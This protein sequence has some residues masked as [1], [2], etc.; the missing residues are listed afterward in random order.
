M[1]ET[2]TYLL[3]FITF[4]LCFAFMTLFDNKVTGQM[5]TSSS[6]GF[7]PCIECALPVCSSGQ[8]LSVSADSCTEC[9][10]CI[11]DCKCPDGER[12]DGE[13]CVSNS[14]GVACIALYAPVCGCDSKTYGNSCVAAGEGVKHFTQ[15]ECDSSSSGEISIPC[16]EDKDCPPGECP[17]GTTYTN[18]SCQD[19]KCFQ[20]QFFADPCLFHQ[21]SSSSGSI[22]GIDLNKK[23]VGIWKA[24]LPECNPE[25]IIGREI[26]FEDRNCIKCE[27][28]QILCIRGTVRVPDSCKEC[29]HCEKCSDLGFISLKLCV[30]NAILS[31]TSSPFGILES[32]SMI[33]SQKI[34]SANEIEVTFQDENEN[35][36]TVT[37]KLKNPRRLIIRFLTEHTARAKKIS[38]NIECFETSSSSS[39]SSSGG[40]E[41]C[42]SRGSCR[43]LNEEELPCPAGTECSGLPAYGCYPPGCPVPICL[44][45]DTK[46]RTNEIKKRVSDIQIGDIVLSDGEKPAKVIK[47]TKVEVQNH[48][49]LRILL[50][51]ATVLEAS[52]GHPTADGRTL[53]DLKKG[54]QLDG[55]VIVKTELI[56]YNYKYTYD[57]LP[58]SETGNYYANGVLVGSTL[59]K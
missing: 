52:P 11:D 58:D 55:R 46:I 33:T 28:I 12:F 54:D 53:S 21:L 41:D 5:Q 19:G 40:I 49:L 13:K 39:S 20:L 18:Y 36:E 16:N 23:F 2:D 26:K 38:N 9:P 27:P 34:I 37:L 44:S 50:N 57:I 35:S 10:Q 3:L 47:T 8:V 14:N 17:D 30:K 4:F 42:S 22:S 43:G 45:L 24:R 56:P 59:K 6:S 1:K 32:D 15:G 31:G 51:D 25:T 48:K 7:S 29:T